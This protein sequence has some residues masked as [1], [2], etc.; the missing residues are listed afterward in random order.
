MGDPSAELA[1]AQRHL[2]PNYSPQPF[3]LE[4]GRGCEVWDTA[5]KR[6]LDLCAGVAVCSV[7]HAH[8]R[9]VQAL[10]EQVA[11]LEHVSNWFYNARNIEAAA[12]LCALSGFDR[13]MFCNSGCEAN[14]ILL[15]LARRHFYSKGERE[16]TRIVAFTG[17]FHGRTLGALSLTGTPEYREGF[18]TPG[19]VTHVPYGDAGAVQA[20][21][22]PDVAAVVVEPLTGEG[23]VV[24]PPV[25]F[26]Q[27][28]RALCDE[29]GS[30]L[31]FDE[32]QT[33]IGRLGAW[34]AFQKSGV[35]PDA[36]SLAKGLGG[37]FPV[38]AVLTREALAGALPP[39]THGSTYAG[40]PLASAA[41]LS[42]LD[43][44][45]REALVAGAEKKGAR[46]AAGLAKIAA[47][48]PRLCEGSRG[49]GLLQG[50]VLRPPL[51]AGELVHKACAQGYLVIGAG[52][53]VLRF[54][55]PLVISESQIDEGLEAVRALLAE[56]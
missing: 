17:A 5:G 34:F 6:Y 14:E 16:R 9:Y 24:P 2:Y 21:L 13:A 44:C 30:L 41:M 19:G 46:L 47:E 10:S 39:G 54:A 51:S 40:N 29:A 26:L 3:V 49:E 37:G 12:R 45:E 31:L 1:L 27:Q 28:L 38:G 42:V 48:F 7:G 15:K 11:T 4:R 43:I 36:V 33:G 25:G 52:A 18:G 50:L 56:L 8:P 53:Q 32:V 20:A 55:P 35:E 23:G 22:G